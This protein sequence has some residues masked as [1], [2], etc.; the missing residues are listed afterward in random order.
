ME[1]TSLCARVCIVYVCLYVCKYA[2]LH[3]NTHLLTLFYLKIWL[4]EF[5]YDVAR[6]HLQKCQKFTHT[7]FA[8][9]QCTIAVFFI[10]LQLSIYLILGVKKN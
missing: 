8:A 2:P 1:L 3:T 10:I 6:V 4:I 7:F 5:E 9:S